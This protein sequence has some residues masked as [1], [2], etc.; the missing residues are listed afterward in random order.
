MFGQQCLLG[1]A[2]LS[3]VQSESRFYP[4]FIQISSRFYPDF[5]QIFY[6]SFTDFIQ[7]LSKFY[8]DLQQIFKKL[9]LP[10]FYPDFI[11]ILPK[12]SPDKIK[13]VWSKIFERNFRVDVKNRGNSIFFFKMDVIYG[14][15]LAFNCQQQ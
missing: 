15:P 8:P 13:Y 2:H 7:I 3:A 14:G 12:F 1:S 10:K 5:I 9:I 11:L 4:D 6:R